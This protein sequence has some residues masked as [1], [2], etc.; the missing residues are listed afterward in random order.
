MWNKLQTDLTNHDQHAQLFRDTIALVQG[1]LVGV[2][3]YLPPY[4]KDFH[5]QYISFIRQQSPRL[6]IVLLFLLPPTLSFFFGM[7]YILVKA[8]FSKWAAAEI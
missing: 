5:W 2:V 7:Q 8:L 3:L 6:K 4:F 1:R